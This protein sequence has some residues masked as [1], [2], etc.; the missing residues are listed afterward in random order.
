MSKQLTLLWL[1]IISISILLPGC[2]DS[3]IVGEPI[4]R[5]VKF[6]VVGEYGREKVR[7]MPGKID[8]AKQADL[9]FQVSG[10]L[11][12]LAVTS[13]QNVNKDQVLAKL[14]ARDFKS[15][16][17]ASTARLARAESD[18]KRVTELVNRKLI[19]R[20]DY[21]AKLAE[22]NIAKAEMERSQKAFNETI[23]KAP[24]AGVIGKKFVDN[25][26]EIQAKE[27]IISLQDTSSFEV[28][29]NIPESLIMRADSAREQVSLNAK[30]DTL[31]ERGF[32]LKIKEFNTEIDSA[33]Q[34]FEATLSMDK[35]EGIT[36]YPGMSVDVIAIVPATLESGN[37]LLPATAIFANP[38]AENSTAVWLID[39][40]SQTVT[41]REIQIG[42]IQGS[43]I[44]VLAGLEKGD[45]IVTAGLHHL[46]AGQQVKLLK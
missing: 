34:T 30:F 21:D 3:I 31:P 33:T 41:L 44:N 15:S 2:E 24:F 18:F 43:N 9:S 12:E 38:E 6:V 39:S 10:K 25:F 20:S 36:V 17:D 19:A 45:L 1:A 27:P 23:L 28:H 13:G 11:I 8:A 26:Q 22:Y 46:N 5:P 37:F 29:I 40:Q 32:P 35:P 16:L 4:I 14:D 42:N 7:H